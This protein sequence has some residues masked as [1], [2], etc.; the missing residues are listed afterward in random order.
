MIEVGHHLVGTCRPSGDT[1]QRFTVQL[2]KRFKTRL[3][4]ADKLWV[5]IYK[6][7]KPTTRMF[8]ISADSVSLPGNSSQRKPKNFPS[9]EKTSLLKIL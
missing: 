8:V 7:S 1:Y 6:S 5:A 2:F 3:L 9:S 4:V